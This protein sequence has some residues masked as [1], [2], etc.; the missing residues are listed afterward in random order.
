[1]DIWVIMLTLLN[2]SFAFIQRLK[3]LV[4][5]FTVINIYSKENRISLKN[6]RTYIRSMD[7]MHGKLIAVFNPQL[8]EIRREHYYEHSSNE[9]VVIE[10]YA[11]N[12]AER[13]FKHMKSDLPMLQSRM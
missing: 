2:P 12:T 13:A 4:F 8:K 6:T 9:E 10:Y 7:F 1:M 11:K 3:S 5:P